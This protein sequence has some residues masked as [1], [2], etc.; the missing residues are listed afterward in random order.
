MM[1]EFCKTPIY[2][3]RTTF[4]FYTTVYHSSC[5]E[6]IEEQKKLLKKK[7]EIEKS[8]IELDGRMARHKRLR[9]REN[10]DTLENPIPT[11]EENIFRE[12]DKYNL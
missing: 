3:W 12:P 1:C 2:G 11:Q 8:L 5:I 7:K 10:P 9:R 4:L 6:L